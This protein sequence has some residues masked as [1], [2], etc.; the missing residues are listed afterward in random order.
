[1]CLTGVVVWWP[2]L[3]R[4]AQAFTVHFDRG[5]RRLV[6]ELHGAAAIW[7]LALL[8]AWAVSGIY[9]SFPGPFRE[10]TARVMTLT[11]YASVQSGPPQSAPAPAPSDLVRR[12]RARV[13]AAQLARFG[14][15]SG[16][17]GAYSVTLAR[18][19][20]G[21]GDSSDEVT[22]YFDRY[23][24]AELSVA[25]QAGRTTGD[26]F[27]TWLGRIHVGNF[28]G[29]PIR[30]VWFAAGLVFPL[31]FVTGVVMWWNRF[32][33][34]RLRVADGSNIRVA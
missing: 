21:D 19:H 30:I 1:M 28:G 3:T 27:L 25:D 4:V 18:E 7:S 13:P 17:R 9:F 24:G 26:V 12:A 22:V 2:G 15:P 10:G 16:E 6:W 34:P 5:W 31:L 29:M 14:V 33:R 32:V 11:P 23:T 20:H 8:I